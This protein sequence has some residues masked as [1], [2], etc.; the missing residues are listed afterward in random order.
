MNVLVRDDGRVSLAATNLS[1]SFGW[2]PTAVRVLAGIDLSLQTHELTLMLGPS[3][4][5]KSTLLSCIA[6]LL[7]PDAGEVTALGHDIWSLGA[8]QI[9][10][11]R[12]R[13]CGFIFQ[14]FNLFGALSAREQVQVVL[15]YGG[16]STAEAFDRARTVLKQVGLGHRLD[17]R[18]AELS[19]GE[20]QRVAIARALA[21]QPD[22]LFA[23]EPTSALDGENGQIVV[24]LLHDAAHRGATVLCV[25]HDHR[26]LDFADR[27]IE[28][29]DGRIVSDRLGAAPSHA[30]RT[31]EAV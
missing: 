29:E 27:V 3:G 16:V 14:G 28:M 2:G 18:P 15:E 1:K 10:Q 17:L 30:S 6:G 19:G 12:L 24:E 13:H 7:R 26:L 8:R 5:G 23:D 22:F 4:S 31:G 20:K 25:T 21:K 11:F 9:E